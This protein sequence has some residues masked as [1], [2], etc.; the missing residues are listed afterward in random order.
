MFWFIIMPYNITFLMLAGIVIS[1]TIAAPRYGVK[2]RPVFWWGTFIAFFTSIPTCAATLKIVDH[3][4]L[5]EF[6]YSSFQEVNDWRVERYMPDGATDIT[7]L[8]T[9][10]GYHAKY[11]I[12]KHSLESW[13]EKFLH[14]NWPKYRGSGIGSDDYLEIE[15][16][17]FELVFC[18]T[19]WK[20]PKDVIR[21]KSASSGN[22]AGFQVWYSES[23]GMAYEISA[24]W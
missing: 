24:Y 22:G 2:R 8:K 12:D 14:V 1:A 21:C 18:D 16:A 13:I 7:M 3:F 20:L 19:G 9:Y 15:Y 17:W 6:T 4:R 5:G 10:N 11:K 23:E